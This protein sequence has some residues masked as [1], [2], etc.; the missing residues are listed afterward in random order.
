MQSANGIPLL[1][2]GT[3]PLRDDE[4]ERCVAMALEVGFRHVD[5][6]QMYGNEM[7]VGRALKA[8]GVARGDLYIVTKIDPGNTAAKNFRTAA[9]KSAEALGGPVDLLLI[10]W[11]PPDAELDAY[12]DRLAE[13]HAAGLAKNIGV[14][15]FPTALMRRAAERSSVQLINNQVEFHAL[16]DQSKVMVEAQQL[17][18]TLSAYCPLGR[19]MVL[20]EPV[21]LGIAK[22]HG[23]PPSEIALRWIVQQGI[24]AIPMTTK[25]D[26]AASNFKALSFSLPQEDMRAISALT[27]RHRRLISPASMA[28]RW[29]N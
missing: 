28:G 7:H 1:G 14:S 6:A 19:G 10:H 27:A 15:N 17:G 24:A 3:F 25:R 2:F 12:V 11:P 23:R 9:E 22:K 18:M 16:I 8:S 4:V 13:T 21:I 20:K 5:T 26:N 29:D